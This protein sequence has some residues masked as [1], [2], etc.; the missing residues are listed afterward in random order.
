MDTQP[1]TGGAP[2]PESR[3]GGAPMTTVTRGL[4][5]FY[6][7]YIMGGENAVLLENRSPRFL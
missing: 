7:A 2:L 6:S 4:R 5:N 1:L 3:V